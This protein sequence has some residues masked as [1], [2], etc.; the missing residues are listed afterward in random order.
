LYRDTDFTLRGLIP[1]FQVQ[2]TG[3]ELM[4]REEGALGGPA[5]FFY[6]FPSQGTVRAGYSWVS[7]PWL[8]EQNNPVYRCRHFYFMKYSYPL[9]SRVDGPRSPLG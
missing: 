6:F 2:G 7:L 4:D 1:V 3:A 5:D 8:K 9:V